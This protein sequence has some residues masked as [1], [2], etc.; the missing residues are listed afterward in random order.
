MAGFAVLGVV[1]G[2]AASGL[3]TA[4]A[5]LVIT[6]L[7]GTDWQFAPGAA[8]TGLALC[9]AVALVIGFAGTWRALGRKAAPVLRHD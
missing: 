7:M 1:A 4:G 9:L 5:W 8:L 6:R 3:G 2:L